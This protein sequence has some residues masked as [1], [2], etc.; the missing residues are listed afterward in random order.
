LPVIAH[1]RRII[2]PKIGIKGDISPGKVAFFALKEGKKAPS[3]RFRA[4]S[5]PFSVFK[6]TISYKKLAFIKKEFILVTE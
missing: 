2:F 5:F 4:K 1:L 3:G 6:Q